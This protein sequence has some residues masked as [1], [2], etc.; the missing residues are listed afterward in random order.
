MASNEGER[1][2]DE[3]KPCTEAAM[4]LWTNTGAPRTWLS[5]ESV[6]NT[7]CIHL[8]HLLPVGDHLR[9]EAKNRPI[10]MV[11]GSLVNEVEHPAAGLL[12]NISRTARPSKPRRMNP[13]SS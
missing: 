13:S 9:K 2:R 5:Q 3:A 1:G 10:S 12:R 4:E 11:S 8:S 6:G 7:S